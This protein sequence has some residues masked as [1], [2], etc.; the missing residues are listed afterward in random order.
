MGA[1]V[2]LHKTC[3]KQ[4]LQAQLRMYLNIDRDTT[5]LVA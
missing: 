5:E 3:S 2:G 1:L 4:A